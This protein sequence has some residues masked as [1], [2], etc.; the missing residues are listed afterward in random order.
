MKDARKRQVY[1]LDSASYIASVQERQEE[2]DRTL[3]PGFYTMYRGKKIERKQVYE[4]KNNSNSAN[5]YDRPYATYAYNSK[6]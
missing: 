1:N 2:V 3:L 5:Y 6:R 4:K